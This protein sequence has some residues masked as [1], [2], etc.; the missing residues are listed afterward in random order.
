MTT[1]Q[2]LIAFLSSSVVGGIVGAL[3]TGKYNLWAKDR[4]YENE[5]FKLV[6]AKRISAYEEL[7][8]LVTGLKTAVVG[9]DNQPYHMIFSKDDDWLS[10]N[11]LLYNILSQ[12]LWITDDLLQKIIELN[13]LNF[14]GYKSGAN[15]TD[16]AKE[17]YQTIALLREEI[18]RKRTR[19]MLSLHK[20][21]IFLKS[22]RVEGGF[23][24][25][26]L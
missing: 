12:T 15:V 4:D 13:R 16:F 22:K 11:K 20:V 7:E 9:D 8:V 24:E 3:I 25:L 21:A 18:E 17:H 6:L 10:I 1:E 5:Y 2:L 23:S 14:R 26:S 19:D